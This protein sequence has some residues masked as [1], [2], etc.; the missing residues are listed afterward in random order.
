MALV[1]FSIQKMITKRNSSDTVNLKQPR[2]HNAA[3]GKWT[4]LYRLKIGFSSLVWTLFFKQ[5]K[6]VCFRLSTSFCIVVLVSSD[7][8]GTPLFECRHFCF[9][10]PGEFRL[11]FIG[12]GSESSDCNLENTSAHSFVFCFSDHAKQAEGAEHLSP[13]YCLFSTMDFSSQEV[14]S[15]LERSYPLGCLPTLVYRCINYDGPTPPSPDNPS[16]SHPFQF[17]LCWNCPPWETTCCSPPTIADS[18]TLC[19]LF[20]NLGTVQTFS[21]R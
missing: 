6:I 11:I 7:A 10:I 2:K 21:P 9:F 20:W 16:V 15:C 13:F 19:P 12:T 8:I 18:H 14:T 1:H 5:K 3:V 4:L 17:W